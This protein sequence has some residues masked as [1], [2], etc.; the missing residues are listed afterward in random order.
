MLRNI[1]F[2]HHETVFVPHIIHKSIVCETSPVNEQDTDEE[3]ERVTN[4]L[5]ETASTGDLAVAN[6]E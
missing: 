6:K 5:Y 1:S 4:F 2:I 3:R